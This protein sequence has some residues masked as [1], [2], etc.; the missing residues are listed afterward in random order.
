M[1][2][3]HRLKRGLQTLP[4]EYPIISVSRRTDFSNRSHSIAS[5]PLA[6]EIARLTAIARGIAMVRP[7]P[8]ETLVP[9][10]GSRPHAP[11]DINNIVPRL[12]VRRAAGAAPQLRHFFHALQGVHAITC[13]Y[14]TRSPNQLSPTHYDT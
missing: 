12:R 7:P 3:V 11:Q 14:G 9:N 1:V 5:R 6:K 10:E 8:R 4:R 13:A 2:E